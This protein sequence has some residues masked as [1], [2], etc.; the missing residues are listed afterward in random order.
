[1]ATRKPFVRKVSIVLTGTDRQ[2]LLAQLER[3]D[4]SLRYIRRVQVIL[5]SDEGLK[6]VDIARRLKLSVGQVSRIRKVFQALGP[7]SLADKPH[8]GRRDHAV[9]RERVALILRLAASPP[10]HGRKRWST[11]LIAAEVGLTSPTVAKV[12][13]SVSRSVEHD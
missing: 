9:S 2:R 11:R 5:L 3:D 7:S 13:R 10:P 1:V 12:L 4:A 8:P 6:G